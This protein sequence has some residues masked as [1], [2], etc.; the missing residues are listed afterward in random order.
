MSTSDEALAG[1]RLN[2]ALANEIGKLSTDFTGRGATKSRAFVDQDVVVCLLENGATR[3]EVNLVAAGKAELVR[4]QRD[5]LQRAREPQ[6]V[7][8][9]ERLTGRTVRTYLSGTS[10]LGG[11]SVEVFV[12]N[13]PRQARSN[14]QSLS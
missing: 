1:G 14:P 3:A 8:A 9:V 4:L 13:P 12:L 7:A 6:L 2:A 11:D 10:T 5:A